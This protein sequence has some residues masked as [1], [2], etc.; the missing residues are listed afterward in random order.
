MYPLEELAG[1]GIEVH[2]FWYNHNIHPYTEYRKRLESL[3]YLANRQNLHLI[4]EDK[5]DLPVFLDEVKGNIG[6]PD[7]CDTCYETRLRQTALKAKEQGFDAFSSTL[8]YSRYQK[9]SVIRSIGER[10]ASEYGLKFH[11]TDWRHGWRRGIEL[12]KE[13]GLYRQQYC[14]CIL[15]EMDRYMPGEN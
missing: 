11:Y 3:L 5:Y 8:L 1:Q 9:H 2:G 13:L 4:V 14:G 15:S 7:R 6:F 12:S 10:I